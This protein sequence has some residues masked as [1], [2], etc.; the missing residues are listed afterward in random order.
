IA[1]VLEANKNKAEEQL[2]A[3][4]AQI[5]DGLQQMK[6]I[7]GEARTLL[8]EWRQYREHGPVPPT[9]NPDRTYKDAFRQLTETLAEAEKHLAELKLLKLP[10]LFKGKRPT[11]LFVVPLLL[12][13]GPSLAITKFEVPDVLFGLAVCVASAC[14]IGF[15]LS[16]WLYNAASKQIL[17]VYQPLCQTL[18]DAELATQRCREQARAA[19]QGQMAKAKKRHDRDLKEAMEK[20]RK[21]RDAV[22]QRRN[23]AW[24]AAQEKYQK[25]RADST[26]RRDTDLRLAHERYQRLRT[27]IYERYETDS[28]KIH[29]R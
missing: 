12:A 22:K 3:D 4:Q 13:I 24:K 16:L 8:K 26:H 14:V 1:T 23:V 25:D 28:Q 18:S 7:Q 19:H 10:G 29:Q 20:F 9:S 27:E 6:A 2:R 17:K 15:S 21:Q 11:W 5:A